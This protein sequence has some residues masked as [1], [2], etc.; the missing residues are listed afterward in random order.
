MSRVEKN[1]N[2]NKNKD[3]N[4]SSLKVSI[5]VSQ[6]NSQITES[7]Y[8]AAFLKLKKLGVQSSNIS[9][10]NVSGSFELIFGCKLAIKDKPDSVIAIGSLIKGETKHF[11]FLS[12]AIANGVK[13][14]NILFDVPIIFSV[15]TDNN[16]E[17]AINRSGGKYG[18][19]GDEAALAAVEMALL[20]KNK[21]QS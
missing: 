17:Q 8:E 10:I 15:L 16:L 2:L 13:D 18:N 4:G 14:L 5:V 19:K 3:L 12:N 20:N 9:R 7:L 11:D 1:K 21:I 6:W